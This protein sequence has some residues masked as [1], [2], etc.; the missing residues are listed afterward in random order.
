M[1]CTFVT[2]HFTQRP[3]KSFIGKKKN[4]Q[5]VCNVNYKSRLTLSLLGVRVE[6]RGLAEACSRD[7]AADVANS[8]AYEKSERTDAS[9]LLNLNFLSVN[10]LLFP[11][12][13]SRWGRSTI[14]IQFSLGVSFHGR[15]LGV[16]PTLGC[17]SASGGN[18][19]NSPWLAPQATQMQTS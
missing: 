10:S 6:K 5:G 17:P 16:V 13:R 7:L 8:G 4:G 18:Q 12:T 11:D 19:V 3:N 1:P 15:K 2:A 14:I 9:S